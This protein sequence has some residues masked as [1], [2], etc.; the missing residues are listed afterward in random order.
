[1]VLGVRILAQSMTDKEDAMH[2]ALNM[3]DVAYEMYE[4]EELMRELL[5][6]EAIDG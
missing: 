5:E 3:S 2:E 4:Q 6:E 1:M